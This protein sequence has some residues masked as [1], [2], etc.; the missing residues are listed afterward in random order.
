MCGCGKPFVA[1]P[2]GKGKDTHMCVD[3]RSIRS[4]PGRA[5]E[6]VHVCVC[7]VS[8]ALCAEMGEALCACV[9]V[10][11]VCGSP[12]GRGRGRNCVHE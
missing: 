12:R 11:G 8:S 6:R 1:P 10:E 4:S 7:E 3:V 2:E 5:G 9:D